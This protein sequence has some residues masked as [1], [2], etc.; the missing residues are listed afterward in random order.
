[1][2]LLSWSDSYRV[3]IKQIDDQHKKLIEMIN[4]LHDAMKVGKGSQVL[5]E[6]LKSLIDY[7][8]SHFATEEKLMKLH[9]YPDYEHHKKE[10]NLLVMQVLDIQKN[11]Q[12]G[13]APLTQNIMSFL[14][15]W[16]VKHIQGEDK[17]YGPYLNGKGVV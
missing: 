12:N 13:S 6:V 14:K 8:G 7:T 15:E 10:H 1:M 11:L 17:K 5:G 4:T 16:L 9:N 2:A 3:N